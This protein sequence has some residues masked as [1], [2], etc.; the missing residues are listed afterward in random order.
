ML[1]ELDLREVQELRNS[2]GEL[3]AIAHKVAEDMLSGKR[4]V[5]KEKTT[6]SSHSYVVYRY[7]HKLYRFQIAGEFFV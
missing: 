1:R 3:G 5:M 6:R 4:V 7:D 2:E